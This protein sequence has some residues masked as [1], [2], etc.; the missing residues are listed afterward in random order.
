[1]SIIMNQLLIFIDKK[2]EKWISTFNT[3]QQNIQLLKDKIINN[4]TQRNN[5]FDIN[6]QKC[7]STFFIILIF[8]HI[9]CLYFLKNKF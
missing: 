4:K 8:T 9:I 7:Y 6:I 5:D 3:P 2:A 1:M